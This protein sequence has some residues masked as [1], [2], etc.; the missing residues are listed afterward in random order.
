MYVLLNFNFRELVYFRRDRRLLFICLFLHSYF[1]LAI[2]QIIDHRFFLNMF[3]FCHITLFISLRL[4][5]PLILFNGKYRD[6]FFP[7]ENFWFDAFPTNGWA[8]PCKTREKREYTSLENRTR[9]N[10]F[11]DKYTAYVIASPIFVFPISVRS[12]EQ[13]A[14][15]ALFHYKLVSEKKKN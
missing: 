5:E 14:N 7:R 8:I 9:I 10:L 6:N 13:N 12:V 15:F 3:F 2:L 11:K 4:I 1:L